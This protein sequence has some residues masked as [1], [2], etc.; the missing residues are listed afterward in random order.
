MAMT[1][2]AAK[3]EAEGTRKNRWRLCS[4]PCFD[5]GQEAKK[6]VYFSVEHRSLT[7][8]RKKKKD[9]ERKDVKPYCWSFPLS[10]AFD[11]VSLF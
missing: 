3:L 8:G 7:M 5:V 2:G 4:S 9:D 6:L 10:F 11:L 1:H